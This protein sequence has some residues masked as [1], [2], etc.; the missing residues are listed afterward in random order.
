MECKVLSCKTITC[1]GSMLTQRSQ[2]LAERLRDEEALYDACFA[3]GAVWLAI[4]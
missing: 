1:H 4:S 2:Y 3:A